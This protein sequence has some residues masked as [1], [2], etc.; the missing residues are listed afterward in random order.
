MEP[1]AG[2][3]AVFKEMI[4]GGIRYFS[5]LIRAAFIP[6]TFKKGEDSVEYGDWGHDGKK[7]G[8]WL[9]SCL[10]HVR[11]TYSSLIQL[12]LPSQ[13]LDIIKALT[14]DLRIQS[15]QVIFQTVIDEIH[16]LHEKEDW[17]QDITDQYGS[18]T[19]LP[20]MFASIVAESV[21]LIKEALMPGENGR[22][23]D[24][25]SYKNAHADLE[26]LIQNVLSSFAFTLEN[27]ALEE[28]NSET[29]Y[30]PPETTRL[31]SLFLV[32]LPSTVKYLWDV[33]ILSFEKK[34]RK[35]VSICTARLIAQPEYA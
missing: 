4:L 13:A 1:D 27:A 11:T 6:Q 33:M 7:G 18:I 28:Y 15:L 31:V 19:E 2:K 9:P 10:R 17:K 21:Q 30:I 12:D 23:E 24:L 8:T 20:S 25:L 14:T 34:L 22:E 32:S 3:S 29:S 35:T 26:T 16:L 5:N